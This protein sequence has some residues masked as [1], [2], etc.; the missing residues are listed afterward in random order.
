[1]KVSQYLRLS[2]FSAELAAEA[3][4]DL[5]HFFKKTTVSELGHFLE[6]HNQEMLNM[7]MSTFCSDIQCSFAL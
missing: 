6:V 1:M 2:L 7:L 4:R 5:R 3:P